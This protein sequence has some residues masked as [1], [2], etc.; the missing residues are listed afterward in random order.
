[1]I[2]NLL[3]PKSTVKE[4]YLSYFLLFVRVLFGV[5]LMTHGYQ[6]LINF[7]AMS[8]S[9]P[10][11]LHVGSRLSLILAIFG[12][13]ICPIGFILGLLYRLSM[14]PMIFT[15]IIAFFV[16]HGGVVSNGELAFVY[17]MIFI[18]AFLTGPGKFSVDRYLFK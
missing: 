1:M 4:T 5:L 8:G 11:P 14:L 7:E 2:K 3:F 17:L 13:L 16:V 10:D 6:K 18:G 15:M 12:E 9:F